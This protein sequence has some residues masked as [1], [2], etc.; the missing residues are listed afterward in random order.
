[1][2]FLVP[3]IG[4]VGIQ[5]GIGAGAAFSSAG[6]LFSGLTG[7]AGLGG[8]LQAASVVGSS[9]LG[10]VGT[11]TVGALGTIGTIGSFLT[12]AYSAVQT[13]EN[14]I[15][16][17]EEQQALH[18]Y[19]AKIAEKQI[20]VNNYNAHLDAQERKRLV[21]IAIG[22]QTNANYLSGNQDVQNDTRTQLVKELMAIDR[23][24]K[25]ANWNAEVTAQ[26]E[27]LLG[28]FSVSQA[29]RRASTAITSG[30]GQIVRNYAILDTKELTQGYV[31]A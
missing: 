6:G 30:I 1:M 26:K 14:E 25:V 10:P 24:R 13:A 23:S 9:I 19:N 18:D 21:R 27:T 17:G 28:K 4:A 15:R 29:S 5:A 31:G 11:S 20:E 22:Q 12:P 3:L 7:F 8:Y 16:S 2:S